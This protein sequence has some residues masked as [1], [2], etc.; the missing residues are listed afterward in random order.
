[1]KFERALI[2]LRK[3]R[4]VRRSSWHSDVYLDLVTPNDLILIDNSDAAGSE[5]KNWCPDVSSIIA[6]D[7]V[8]CR[9]NIQQA[10]N[11][12]RKGKLVKRQLWQN[13][14]HLEMYKNGSISEIGGSLGSHPWEPQQVDVVMEDWE[15]FY[16]ED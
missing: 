7:W 2:A 11:F 5:N 15:V 1:M 13:P 3:G 14:R 16:E 6:E 8:V 4:C 9:L 12:L 10:L